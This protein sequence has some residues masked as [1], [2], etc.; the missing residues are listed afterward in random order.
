MLAEIE[1]MLNGTIQTTTGISPAEIIFG[2][3]LRHWWKT[4]TKGKI[5]EK[6]NKNII[7]TKRIF[8]VGDKV[9]I[10]KVNLSKDDDRYETS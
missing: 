5:R 7:E 1:F 10:K 4:T 9:L 2:R 8:Q 6:A 3:K